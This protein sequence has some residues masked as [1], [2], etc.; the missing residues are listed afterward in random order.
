M[1]S[2]GHVISCVYNDADNY[3][4]RPRQDRIYRQHLNSYLETW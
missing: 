1:H 2:A 4:T 3:V